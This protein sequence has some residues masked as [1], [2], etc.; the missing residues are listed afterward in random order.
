M[1]GR[2][3]PTSFKK[4]PQPAA[5]ATAATTRAAAYL[6]RGRKPTAASPTPTTRAVSRR[7]DRT[8]RSS[9]QL[10]YVRSGGIHWNVRPG[11]WGACR[12]ATNGT[13]QTTFTA[14][15]NTGVRQATARQRQP[16]GRAQR[17]RRI[18]E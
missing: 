18:R 15:R 3:E 13:S 8:A 17:A 4:S 2:K 12:D 14:T 6:R 5:P 10:W 16:R 7:G 1:T 11:G 9:P